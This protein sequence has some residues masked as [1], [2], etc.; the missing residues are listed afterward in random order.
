MTHKDTEYAAP[1]CDNLTHQSDPNRVETLQMAQ[2]ATPVAPAMPRPLAEP[3][4]ATRIEPGYYDVSPLKP[5]VWSWEIS[6]YF[7]LGGASGG[8]FLMARAAERAGGHRHRAL[9]RAGTWAAL[10][11]ALPCPLLLIADLGDPKRF[12]HMLRVVK[13]SSPMN[14]GAWVLTAHSG[15]VA[16]AALR[17][18][19]MAR[20]GVIGPRSLIDRIGMA[21]IDAAGIP[22]AALL[23]T[24]TGVLISCTANPLWCKNRWLAP[25]FA[26]SAVSTGAEAIGLTL[27]V[28]EPDP[29]AGRESLQTIDS[30]AH[31]VEVACLAGARR[32]ASDRGESLKRGSAAVADRIAFGAL[33]A[34][35]ALK[36]L[37][38]VSRTRGVRALSATL[39]LA[40]GLAL[41]WALVSGGKVAASDARLARTVSRSDRSDT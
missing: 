17:E 9:T 6:V 22:L 39:G 33:V 30:V 10:A 18:L 1:W 7:F 35:E 36:R 15:M 12:H 26:A 32:E 3:P 13:P 27:D 34:A 24:Y 16:L 21:I 11:A 29:S 4:S 5:P 31:A 28:T 40:A 37:G 2:L 25:L 23:A 41:R 14:F 38:P 19:L 8:A 20:G